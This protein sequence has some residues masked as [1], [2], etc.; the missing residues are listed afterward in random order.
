MAY[1]P[2]HIAELITAYF[3]DT[4][5]DAQRVELNIW[6]ETQNN[7]AFLEELSDEGNLPQKLL[8]F[9]RIRERDIW[10]KTL[11]GLQELKAAQSPLY[12]PNILG[13]KLLAIAAAVGLIVLGI[14]FFNYKNSNITVDP[15]LIVQ[16]VAPGTVGATL[17]LANGRKIKLADVASG[18]I[19]DEAGITITKTADGQLNYIMDPTS[20]TAG[21]KAHSSQKSLSMAN[22]LSTA[23]GETYILTLPDKSKVW[24]NAA[25]SLTYSAGLIGRGL[26]SA[27]FVKLE[28]EAYFE[29]AKDKAHP[30]V[31]ESKGQQVEVLG[32][33][34]NIKS[35]PDENIVKTTL[36]EGSVRVAA[37]DPNKRAKAT[38]EEILKPGEQSS[39][40]NNTITVN[41]ADVKREI[42]WKNGDFIFSY[43][44]LEDVMKEVQRWYD[45]KVVY[46]DE[47]LK[48]IKFGGFV[49]RSK[50]ISAIL[51][52][53]TLTK[54]A[55]VKVEG[56]TITIS[57]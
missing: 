33:H 26:R 14:Y 51:R 3:Q 11:R 12:R 50:N 57:P 7:R 32:T 4:L 13:Y 40:T 19:A 44:R 35:Y 5:S 53:V 28:G 37:L 56:K 31:V 34:F 48:D 22:T 24:L 39:F 36:V 10:N 16:D 6:L 18:E 41:E 23:K 45:V 46:Q 8:L 21:I 47:S 30:F 42:A 1:D 38:T 54:R 9:D 49:S 29:I 2:F 25:S 15:H 27:R 43:E 17:T 20:R 52:F 55:H